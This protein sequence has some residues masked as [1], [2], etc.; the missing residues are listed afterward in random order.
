MRRV[1]HTKVTTRRSALWLAI[2]TLFIPGCQ[3]DPTDPGDPGDPPGNG[4]PV[5]QAGADLAVSAGFS[6]TLDGTASTDPEGAALTYAWALTAPAGSS[7]ALDDATS[8]TPSFVPDVAGSYVASLTVNDGEDDSAA[9]D[10]TITAADN[11]VTVTTPAASGGTV[12]SSDG[13]LT[14]EIPAGALGA[15]TDISVTPIG[16]AQLPAAILDIPAE[17]EAYAL[18]PAGTT[19]SSPAEVSFEIA[20]AVTSG[21]G[22]VEIGAAFLLAESGGTVESM[23]DVVLAQDDAD[24]SLATITGGMDH[25]SHAVFASPSIVFRIEGPDVADVGEPFD[26]TFTLDLTGQAE[27]I[28][29]A[30]LTDESTGGVGP[31]AQGVFRTDFPTDGSTVTIVNSYECTSGGPSDVAVALEFASPP[32]TALVKLAKPVTCA[33]PLETAL[34]ENL[35]SAWRLLEVPGSDTHVTVGG[36]IRSLDLQSATV[37]ESVLEGNTDNIEWVA[38]LSDGNYLIYSVIGQAARIVPGGDPVYDTMQVT[39]YDQP[40]HMAMP[41]ANTIALASAFGDLGLITYTPGGQPGGSVSDAFRNLEMS[42]PQQDP[43]TNL[44]AIWA[45]EDLETFIGAVTEGDGDSAFEDTRMA[46]LSVN[47]GEGFIEAIDPLPGVIDR[48]LDPEYRHQFDLECG[49]HV[50]PAR[51]LCVFSSGFSSPAFDN[52][53]IDLEGDG[54]VSI[55]VFDAFDESLDVLFTSTG[56]ARIGAGVFPID[57]TTT[58]GVVVANQ[59]TGNLDV[60]QVEGTNVVGSLSVS[61]EHP[62]A[63]PTDLVLIGDGALGALTCQQPQ[64]FENDVVVIRG[65]NSDAVPAPGN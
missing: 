5:A 22:S 18:G 60:W 2:G 57:G 42:T 4:V 37:S 17:V 47:M 39:P 21:S 43:P 44:Q 11:T 34:I 41:A 15:D 54:F 1:F 31:D 7:A 6:V 14:L 49:E 51:Y 32:L 33:A 28:F 40:R 24:P 13:A 12:A 63:Y 25:F 50:L 45:S 48:V 52:P 36:E 38:S 16:P 26:V 29:S 56:N 3:S 30:T 10:V 65:L 55:F 59:F 53:P 62:C 35:L 46:V 20:D 23:N 58:T 19:F 8:A 64:A 9:D 61:L 27:T